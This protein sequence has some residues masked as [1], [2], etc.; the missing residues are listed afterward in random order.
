MV[1]LGAGK[2]IPSISHQAHWLYAVLGAGFGFSD[3]RS[4]P[5]VCGANARPQAR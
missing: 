5:T 3:S 2:L 4:L 1:S